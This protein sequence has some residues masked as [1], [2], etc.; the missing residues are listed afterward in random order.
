MF[1]KSTEPLLKMST[2]TGLSTGKTTTKSTW[3]TRFSVVLNAQPNTEEDNALQEAI[4]QFLDQ[5]INSSKQDTTEIFFKETNENPQDVFRYVSAN[6]FYVLLSNLLKR[7]ETLGAC[8]RF[9]ANCAKL[10]KALFDK[11]LDREYNEYYRAIIF[12][13]GAAENK[14][15]TSKT[16]PVKEVRT[17]PRIAS[18]AFGIHGTR[19]FLA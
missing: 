6:G 10:M 8:Q 1:R 4:S 18:E 3:A 11:Q 19:S 17:D 13:Q 16:S 5:E 15:E 12:Y 9:A 7:C 2:D 14:A